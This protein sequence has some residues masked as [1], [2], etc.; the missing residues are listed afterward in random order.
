MGGL[1]G[2]RIGAVLPQSSARS[3][4]AGGAVNFYEVPQLACQRPLLFQIEE[5]VDSH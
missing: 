1:L 2:L 5:K 4:E 3:K